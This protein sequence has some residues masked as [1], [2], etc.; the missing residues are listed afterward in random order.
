MCKAAFPPTRYVVYCARDTSD[1]A[2]LPNNW[3]ANCNSALV[4]GRLNERGVFMI[5]LCWRDFF[6][7]TKSLR[8]EVERHPHSPLKYTDHRL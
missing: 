5:V 7:A 2:R 4:A 1:L 6:G 3:V 8:Q